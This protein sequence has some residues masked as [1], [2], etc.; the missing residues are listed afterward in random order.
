MRVLRFDSVGGASGDM[1]LGA[2]VGLGVD[3]KLLEQEIGKLI[4]EHFHLRV[5]EKASFGVTGVHLTVDIHEH[6]RHGRHEGEC[7]QNHSHDH[8]ERLSHEHA[9]THDGKHTHEHAC[10]HDGK[11]VHEHAHTHEHNHEHIHGRT[12][13]SIRSLL[14]S[15]SLNEDAK[16]DALAAFKALATAEAE[17]HNVLVEDVHFHEVGA[18]DSII[19]TVGCALAMSLLNVDGIS[20]S[21]LPIGEGTFRCAHGVYPLPAPATSVLLRDYNLPISYDV[22]QCEMLTP[23]AASLFA[24]WNKVE[25]PAGA[26]LVATVNSFGAREMKSRPNLLRASIYEFDEVDDAFA[27]SSTSNAY[28]VETVYELETNIDDITGERLTTVASSLFKAG[29]L[30]VWFEPIQMKKG[31]P[32]HCLCALVREKDRLPAIDAIFRHSGVLGVRETAKQRYCL[33]RYWRKVT[34]TWGVIRIKVGM[35]KGGDVLSVSPEFDDVESL[36][37]KNDV[38]FEQVYREAVNLFY[39]EQ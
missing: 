11:P 13:A 30:D 8:E 2:L 14:E 24:I 25:I 36:A 33:T 3:S 1:I 9:H 22:E 20:L 35:T 34:T 7:F 39:S 6:G 4:P 15:S 5:E 31:R 23:T 18:V 16:R 10:T 12:Y 17:A 21:P 38:T 32:A 27:A 19:D 28:D 29:A 26:R 37:L